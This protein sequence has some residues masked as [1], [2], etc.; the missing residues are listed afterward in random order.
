VRNGWKEEVAVQ[1]F[2][3]LQLAAV[4][5]FILEAWLDSG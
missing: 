4:H 1:G 2:E 3:P 5:T